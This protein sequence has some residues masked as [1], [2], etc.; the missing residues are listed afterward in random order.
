MWPGGA[1]G[2][3]RGGSSAEP[4]GPAVTRHYSLMALVRTRGLCAAADRDPR[5][6]AIS[7]RVPGSLPGGAQGTS[8]ELG[9][10]RGSP[11]LSAGTGLLP[12]PWGSRAAG[13]PLARLLVLGAGR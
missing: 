4:P 9:G 7:G 12:P 11:R 13:Q 2:A 8:P 3:E 10:A 6:G 5:E 1:A